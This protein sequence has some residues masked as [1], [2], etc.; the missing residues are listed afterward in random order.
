MN[1]VDL[2]GPAPL[3]SAVICT[4]NRA[5]LLQQA[6]D[7]LCNQTIGINRFE[8]VV[9][10]D[11]STDE[12]PKTVERFRSLLSLRYAY[13]RNSGLAS[14]KNH[15]LF[16]SRS[17]IVTF[18]DDDDILDERCLE[19]HY[20]SHQRFPLPNFAVLGYTDLA[21]EPARSPLMHYVTEIGCQ[22]FSYP[23][24]TH[25]SELDFS[26]FWGGRS[27]CK[28]GFLLEHG[29]FNPAFRFGAEDIEL[30][31]RLQ[32]VGLR[33]V[34]NANAIS[35]MV[36]TLN[37]EDF[38]RRCHAQGRSNWLFSR[39]HPDPEVQTWT[40][41]GQA[42]LEWE[43]IAPRF[44]AIMKSARELDRFVGTRADLGLPINETTEALLYRGYRAAFEANRIRG[45]SERMREDP[46]H[47]QTTTLRKPLHPADPSPGE[48]APPLIVTP[49]SRLADYLSL[50]ANLQKN[51]VDGFDIESSIV[52]I[53]STREIEGYCYACD[54]PGRFRV[55]FDHAYRLRG[56]LTPNWRE[57]A[58]CTLCGLNN[59]MRATLHVLNEVVAP[60]QESKIYI[61]ECATPFFKQLKTRYPN[62]VGSEFLGGT[63]A[64]GSTNAA[65][66][67]NEDVTCLSFDDRSFDVVLS[68][69]VLEH[70]P[71]YRSAL[72][73]FARIL[74]PGGT[75]F[76]SIPFRPREETTLVR[77][78]VDELGNI[79]HLTAPEY[80]GDPLRPE[81]CLSFYHFGW[82][83]LDDIRNADFKDVHALHYHSLIYGYL[84]R[85]QLFFAATRI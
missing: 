67:R 52:E 11:G 54:Q 81:G 39:L 21:R 18:L 14:A 58:A 10:D 34:Y 56:K 80:H 79:S 40:R 4:H 17:P 45:T 46:Q 28:R 82:D 35:H 19:E 38:C 71:A 8:V 69:D 43:Q 74:R 37:F 60:T 70:V 27:S 84:G 2:P 47:A 55:T 65:G 15:G 61:T 36:R 22:L 57:T 76:L 3:I 49:L 44:D 5:S 12:T 51:E 77:A 66:I 62:S 25:G 68:F 24:L 23:H 85:D 16:L 9:I 83:L 48:P 53:G 33:V 7:S 50:E 26:Y 13:Q 30:G 59:R 1:P 78:T 6:L 42:A 32:R 31:F 72:S 63:L 73:E 20:L 41:S 29:V 75:L 64:L